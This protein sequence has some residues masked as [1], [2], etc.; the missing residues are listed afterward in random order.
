MPQTV[1]LYKGEATFTGETSFAYAEPP[2]LNSVHKCILFV[3]QS[4]DKEDVNRAVETFAQHDWTKVVI[5]STGRL[6]LESLNQPSIHVFQQ[7][8]EECLDRGD[9]LVWYR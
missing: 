9:S 7:H 3:P 5:A 1:M 6:Q 2:S 8:Y 4:D